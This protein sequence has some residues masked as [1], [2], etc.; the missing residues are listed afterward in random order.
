MNVIFEKMHIFD[1]LS[2]QAFATE[3]EE[4]VNVVTSSSIDG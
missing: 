1:I 3:F 4:G 2:K